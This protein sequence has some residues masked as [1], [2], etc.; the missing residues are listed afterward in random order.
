MRMVLKKTKKKDDHDNYAIVD[1]VVLDVA[2]DDNDD[3]RFI[4]I[5]GANDAHDVTDV[6]VTIKKQ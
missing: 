5:D 6:D 4:N 3:D 2:D 1:K